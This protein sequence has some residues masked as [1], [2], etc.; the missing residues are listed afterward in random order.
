M[1]Y[2]AIRIWCGKFGLEFAKRLRRNHQGHGDTFYLD[3]VF[4][5]IQ[6]KQHYLWRA[7]DRD[8]EVV[9]VFLQS[10]RDGNAAKRCFKRLIGVHGSE[11]RRI[12]TDKLRMRRFNSVNQAQSFLSAHAAIYILFNL[13]RHLISANHYQFFRQRVFTSWK[14]AAV[15]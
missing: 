8:S 6:G 1:S 11:L 10:R 13:G 4:V 12:V 9:D 2:E 15:L 7:V 5:K 3:D 14:K